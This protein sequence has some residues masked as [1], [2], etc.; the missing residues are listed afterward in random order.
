[1]RSY[2]I[3]L[4]LLASI[5]IKAIEPEVTERLPVVSGYIRDAK[6][7][8]LLIGA[9]IFNSSQKVGTTSNLYGF[10]SLG[11]TK[12]EQKFVFSF[13]GYKSIEKVIVVSDDV[14]LSVELEAAITNLRE[15]KVVA[16]QSHTKIDDPMM[17]VQKLQASAIKQVPVLM[18]EVDAIKVIQLLPGVSS[19][20]EGSS[21]FSVRGG[22]PDHNLVLLD[23]ATVYNAG[24]LLGFFSV[25]NNDVIK[26]LSLYKGDIPA[27]S[28]GRLASLLDIRM[29]D[30][31]S[32]KFGATGGI[33][34][35]SSR[36][37]LEG[38]V[39]SEKTTFVVAG[40]RTYADM[41]LPLSSN[42]AV[43]DNKLFFYDVNAKINH[44]F[45]DKNRIY[46]SGYFGRDVYENNYSSID[47][48]NQT[49]TFR[50]NHVFSPRLFSNIT[51]IS[52]NYDYGL[53][54]SAEDATGF[55]WVSNMKDYSA[56]IDLN[57]Y[58]NSNHSISFGTQSI[59]H[60]IMPGWVKG[61]GDN[62]L[63]ND[64]KLSRNYSL[65]HAFY[66]ENT[67]KISDHLIVRYG[68]RVSA[69][70]NIGKGIL[71]EYDEKYK[72]VKTT[73]YDKGDVYNT[74]WGFEPRAGITYLINEKSSIKASYSRTYQYLHLANNS[75]ST[76]PLDVW[77]PSSPNV[78]PQ[79]SDQVSVG[80][81]KQFNNNAFDVSLETFYKEMDNSIDFKDYADLLLNE[82]LE[83]ELRFGKSYAYGIEFLTRFN[84]GRWNGWVGYTWSKSERKIED[85][86]D[87][88]WYNSP[89]NRI[90][91]GSV[92][93]SYKMSSRVTLSANWVYST[94]TP[95]TFPVGRYQSGN[96]IIPI[97][98]DRNAE[99]MPDYHR[100]DVACTL[101][102]KIKP[103]RRWQGEWV[104][105][106]Y[107][108]YG[109]K[110]AW[111]IYFQQDEDD[112]YRTKAM[113]TY[114]F[115]VVPA[116]TYNFKF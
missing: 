8:E 112:A 51:L 60:N 54:T 7:G 109:R 99:R 35:I 6:S 101:S 114:L 106:A 17:G 30:G 90:H 89:Y 79:Q 50:W 94:G 71:H 45:S 24:H 72:V 22:N 53:N 13:L 44:T 110:N 113:K 95:V 15:V 84:Y 96:D 26:D 34:T 28:G 85:V 46:L 93:A 5:V 39:L 62:T 49:L 75:T 20:S 80:V 52:S 57:Y 32:K 16:N 14:S 73:N 107:N 63:Y 103:G 1:M 105:S 36:L 10:Y 88:R 18:G 74:F 11:S 41:F 87:N 92:V 98:S 12:G 59:I 78:K 116:I 23:E 64:L 25:F 40:R 108:A 65:E 102:G 29:K 81:F 82:Y 83:G 3:L 115:S 38:P 55:K 37:T 19:V 77:F 61:I 70:Q 4:M 27:R 9:T 31:N 66:A 86:N 68:L 2:F 48:G 21:G 47:F 42:E 76:T 111:S 100:L 43:R 97:Y 58:P 91:D 56:K 33:G 69:F 67:Q 104:F